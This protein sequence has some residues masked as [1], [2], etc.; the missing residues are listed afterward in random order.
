M[1]N[2][3]RMGGRWDGAASGRPAGGI[4]CNHACSFLQ[5]WLVLLSEQQVE[6]FAK[7]SSLEGWHKIIYLLKLDW[8][9]MK[10]W[11]ASPKCFS[12]KS[13]TRSP[14]QLPRATRMWSEIHTTAAGHYR[15][16]W[17][18]GTTYRG[19]SKLATGDP[20]KSSKMV[21]K[22]WLINKKWKIQTTPVSMLKQI[23]FEQTLT[24]TQG[25]VCGNSIWTV[26]LTV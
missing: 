10:V 21:L 26:T 17:N 18:T 12:S 1:E 16:H 25:Q 8:N 24:K 20:V 15:H 23:V 7:P 13:Y 5:A 4:Q 9:G 6:S 14:R 22:P 3:W 2:S 19:R 11:S